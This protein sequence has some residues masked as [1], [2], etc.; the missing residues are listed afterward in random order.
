MQNDHNNNNNIR[1]EH[2][3]DVGV[4]AGVPEVY[5]CEHIDCCIVFFFQIMFS[6]PNYKA[7]S[8]IVLSTRIIAS[9]ADETETKNPDGSQRYGNIRI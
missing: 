2:R 6:M 7:F 8:G 3:S 1:F 5:C 4:S 9:G